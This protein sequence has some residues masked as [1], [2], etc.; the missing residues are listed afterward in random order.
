MKHRSPS[1]V[2]GPLFSVDG[3]RILTWGS[4]DNTARLWSASDGK[5]VGEPMKHASLV[6]G[7][8]FSPDSRRILTW[9]DDRTARLWSASD[10]KAMGEPM[11]HEAGSF[12][13]C[14]VRMGSAS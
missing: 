11:K 2:A 4:E 6:F 12:A 5:P 8:R 13:P 7:G 3:Q 9:G 1:P 14:T 10:G